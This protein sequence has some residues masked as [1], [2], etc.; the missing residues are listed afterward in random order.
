MASE[1]T[2]WA[3][4]YVKLVYTGGALGN[5]IGFVEKDEGESVQAWWRGSDN[6]C[7][8]QSVRKLR[9]QIVPPSDDDKSWVEQRGLAPLV[10]Y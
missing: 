9:L 7:T 5:N 1:Q 4:K 3:G 8:S 2:N 10:K 6:S